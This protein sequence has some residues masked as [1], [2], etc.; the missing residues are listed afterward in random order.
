[1]ARTHYVK[2]AQ[3]DQGNCRTCGKAIKAGESYKWAKPRTHRGGVGYKVR[4]CSDHSPT[5]AQLTSSP[6]LAALYDA[7]DAANSTISQAGSPEDVQQAVEDFAA[8]VR[9]EVAAGYAES[10][11][12]IESGFGH[13]TST[14]AELREKAEGYEG[15]ADELEAFDAQAAYDDA[16]EADDVDSASDD[17]L[18]AA[19]DACREAAQ[20]ELGNCPV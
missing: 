6:H 20:D 4:W 18:E 15:W 1:M 2:A 7:E 19:M 17:E 11:D 12:N 9:D 5:R 8:A 3:K 16:M 14:S 13:E 10:A